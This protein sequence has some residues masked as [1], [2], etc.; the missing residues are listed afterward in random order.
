LEAPAFLRSFWASGRP[1]ST[2]SP[3]GSLRADRTFEQRHVFQ[4]CNAQSAIPSASTRRISRGGFQT[5][6]LRR[7]DA[8][9]NVY[10]TYFLSALERVGEGGW[11]EEGANAHGNAAN[12]VSYPRTLP[13][14]EDVRVPR[15]CGGARCGRA[16]GSRRRS[17]SRVLTRCGGA[18]CGRAC[19]RDARAPGSRISGSWFLVLV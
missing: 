9:R 18:R 19:G 10:R 8:A 1:T 4:H 13:L 16:C 3:C 14:R 6:P 5:C 12:R 17:P 2:F 11:G 15:Q 7:S